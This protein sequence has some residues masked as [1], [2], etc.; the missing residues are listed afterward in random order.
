[1]LALIL[2]ASLSNPW[3]LQTSR[4]PGAPD[5]IGAYSAG[6]LQGSMPMP[7]DA[8]TYQLLRPQN[9][10]HFGHPNLIHYL[11]HLVTSA[12]NA[13]LPPLLIGDMAMVKGGP[14]TSG[15][16]SHQSGLDADLWF[17]F[18]QP[19]LSSSALRN[20][21]PLDMVAANNREV[22]KSFTRKQALLLQLAASAPEVER[23]F[24]HPAIKQALCVQTRGDRQWLRKIR[25]WFGHR[26]HFHV[27]LNCPSGSHD[28]Q[29]QKPIPYGDGCGSELQS[30]FQGPTEVTANPKANPLPEL[31]DRCM[32]LLNHAS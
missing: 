8:P 32:Q 26:A 1:M 21:Q 23:I 22:S 27:R 18:A 13:G 29:S 24:V 6:C 30:W 17:R 10:R 3:A 9:H 31:P 11:Q 16:R 14:F 12:H 5:A 15:H 19:R 4:A 28:C 20:P 2:A 25:P 7:V